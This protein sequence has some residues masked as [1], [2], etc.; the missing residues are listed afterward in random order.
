[1]LNY[2]FQVVIVRVPSALKPL[3]QAEVN[4][5]FVTTEGRTV[6]GS[7]RSNMVEVHIETSRLEVSL[8]VDRTHTF[9]GD[10]L[11]YTVLV[12]NPG[13]SLRRQMLC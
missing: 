3:N 10:I 11:M 12:N 4:Y 8:Q 13:F 1:M 6:S 5:E 7:E 9:A 2:H